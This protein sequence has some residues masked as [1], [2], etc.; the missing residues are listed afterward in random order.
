LEKG[1]GTFKTKN[2]FM[3]ITSKT[4]EGEIHEFKMTMQG[5]ENRKKFNEEENKAMVLRKKLSQ[6]S[7]ELMLE[8][9]D[10]MEAHSI[11]IN[12]IKDNQRKIGEID[13]QIALIQEETSR[14]QCLQEDLKL[15]LNTNIQTYDSDILK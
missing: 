8:D 5:S 14:L 9:I 3:R 7:E 12:K 4:F 13:K 6:L 15:D 1:H 2:K 10:P 11:L